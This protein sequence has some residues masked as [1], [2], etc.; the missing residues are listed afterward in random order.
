[1]LV[2]CPNVGEG[3]GSPVAAL[4]PR[5]VTSPPKFG[6]LITLKKSRFPTGKLVAEQIDGHARCE[7]GS[8]RRC[9]P[10]GKQSEGRDRQRQRGAQ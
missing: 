5:P 6:R 3:A 1:M 8:D 4:K 9:L 7:I 2:A 10:Q